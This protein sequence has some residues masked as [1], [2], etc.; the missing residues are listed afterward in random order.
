MN[1]YGVTTAFSSID[2]NVADMDKFWGG[3]IDCALF[4][5]LFSKKCQLLYIASRL[6]VINAEPGVYTK[7]ALINQLILDD[8]GIIPIGIR[9]WST[10]S[11]FWLHNSRRMSEGMVI[12]FELIQ[13][14]SR[15]PKT[16][17]KG[18]F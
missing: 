4:C 13:H 10:Q 7:E 16:L 8:L 11:Y 6:A 9:T 2:P 15:L 5:R 18:E 3:S 1:A 14:R 17:L 12:P